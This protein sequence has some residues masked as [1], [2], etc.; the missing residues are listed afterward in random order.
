MNSTT[1]GNY[2]F[3]RRSGT[4]KVTK[5]TAR[6]L[7][8][9]GVES[10]VSCGAFAAISTDT[11]TG[12]CIVWKSASA[13]G[14]RPY[15][16]SVTSLGATMSG[17]A[18][19]T[20]CGS[21]SNGAGSFQTFSKQRPD[22]MMEIKTDDIFRLLE[23]SDSAD[24]LF[25]RPGEFK[26]AAQLLD[27]IYI[28]YFANT[29]PPFSYGSRWHLRRGDYPTQLGLDWKWLLTTNGKS[30]IWPLST[31]QGTPEK[32]WFVN[33]SRWVV[34]SQMPQ[35]TVV[36]G[37]Y[38]KWLIETILTHPKAAYFLIPNLMQPVSPK[39]FETN[40]LDFVAVATNFLSAP[41]DIEN[42]FLVQ[43]ADCPDEIKGRWTRR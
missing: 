10:G 21:S 6:I 12:E 15:C 19:G 22:G 20:F 11:M 9:R 23:R 2:W 42:R 34:S 5:I 43:T 8:H 31:L 28:N 39:E 41:P 32:Y 38:D 24:T 29:Y 13:V 3:Y 18:E 37:G 17:L 40:K 33:D 7:F 36:L 25:V 16:I 35:Y 14:K 1:N 4:A 30:S 27:E 26:T